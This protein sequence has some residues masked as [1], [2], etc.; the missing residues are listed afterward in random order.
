MK[1]RYFIRLAF[2]GNQYHGWQIQPNGI[3]IQEKIQTALKVILKK[4]VLIIGA[5]R[6]DTG[7]HAREFFAHFDFDKAINENDINVLCYQLNSILPEDISIMKITR[8]RHEAHARF[9]ATARTYSYYFHTQK[10]PFLQKYSYFITAK[11]DITSMQNACPIL[12]EY[13]DF[14]CFSKSHTQVKTNNCKIISA[15]WRMQGHQIIFTITA[16]RF[17]RNMVRAIVGTMLE[18]G[19]GKTDT[20]GFKDVIESKNRSKAGYSVPA[21]GLFLEKIEYPKEIFLDI[22]KLS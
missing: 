4:E 18:I 6:T 8:V 11:L 20:N 1:F 17:L 16:D 21:C 2:D 13:N 9:D 3:T 12:Y 15:E 10:D 5:G 22:E 14:S 7:V 19:Y